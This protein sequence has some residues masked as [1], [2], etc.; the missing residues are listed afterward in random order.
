[1]SFSVRAV[2]K[3]SYVGAE[4]RRLLGIHE[5]LPARVR[6]KDS[7]GDLLEFEEWQFRFIAAGFYEPMSLW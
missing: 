5:R 1:M 3:L 7:D 6:G 4:R 2:N